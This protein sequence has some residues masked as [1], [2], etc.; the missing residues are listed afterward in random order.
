MKRP[1]KSATVSDLVK[2]QSKIMRN[3]VKKTTK[4]YTDK[5]K[6]KLK[7]VGKRRP[8]NGNQRSDK[9]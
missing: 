6:G 8:N 3:R 5:Y 1:P 9:E 7:A 4:R 2:T